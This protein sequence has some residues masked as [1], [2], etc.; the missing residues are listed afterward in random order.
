MT[1][2]IG[3]PILRLMK[4]QL[5]GVLVL[6]AICTPAAGAAAQAERAGTER[7]REVYVSVIDNRGAP[8]SG[9]AAADFTVKE[10]GKPREVLAVRAAETPLDLVVLIDDSAAATEAT[11]HLRDGLVAMLERLHGKAQISLM[12]HGDRPTMLAPFTRDTADLQQK[13]RRI[14]P[15]SGSGAY[16]LDALMEAS[17]SLAKR[18]AERP[19]IVAITFEGV[20]YSN[21]NDQ[22]VLD[23]LQKSGAALHVVAVGSPSSSLEDEMRN[24]NMVIAEGTSRTGGRRD[25][26]LAVSGLPDKLKQVAD[27]LV[28]QYVLTYG[29]PDT[30]VPPE[31]LEVTTTR[32]RVTVRARTRLL[33]VR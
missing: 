11:T 20:E 21:R 22:P 12:T 18:N 24:R 8:V 17:V 7:T 15:R 33:P 25:Q 27:E 28:N 31:K 14:F 5:P 6:L 16:L 23:A 26:V 30:L 3:G 13:V 29:R 9:L 32:P 1:L 4:S 19:V 2:A 10:D